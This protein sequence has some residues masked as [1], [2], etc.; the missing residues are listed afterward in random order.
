M[1]LW[2]GFYKQMV[3]I[4]GYLEISSGKISYVFRTGSIESAMVYLGR[5]VIQLTV[6]GYE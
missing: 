2:L 3:N 1:G 6:I 4:G 5:L